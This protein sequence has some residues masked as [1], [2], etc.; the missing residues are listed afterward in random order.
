MRT[1]KF[2]RKKTRKNII[3]NNVIPLSTIHFVLYF[4]CYIH[5]YI[6]QWKLILKIMAQCF[7]CY[8]PVQNRRFKVHHMRYSRTRIR[9]DLTIR[10]KDTWQASV[11]ESIRRPSKTNEGPDARSTCAER[12]T[13]ECSCIASVVGIRPKGIKVGE[14]RR[15]PM[16]SFERNNQGL[17]FTITW[18]P[19]V[20]VL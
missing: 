16:H 12:A 8:E 11:P 9:S 3:E 1:Y 5:I 18:R 14:K 2:C 15:N 17:H 13:R 7:I 4:L 20:I 6:I 19:L 10:G